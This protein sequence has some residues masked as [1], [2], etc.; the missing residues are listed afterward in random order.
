MSLNKLRK[1]QLRWI[2]DVVLF[3]SLTWYRSCFLHAPPSL[4]S[5]IHWAP[6]GWQPE[7]RH[8][9]N[10]TSAG[11]ALSVYGEAQ[12]KKGNVWSKLCFP[13]H[14]SLLV[15][16]TNSKWQLVLPSKANSTLLENIHLFLSLHIFHASL[17]QVIHLVKLN[18]VIKQHLYCIP[19]IPP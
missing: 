18:P 15:Y 3:T 16:Q 6:C 8:E 11:M 2:I 10:S 12:R 14:I 19:G 5:W 17:D 1:K 13:D 7:R 9:R 4:N